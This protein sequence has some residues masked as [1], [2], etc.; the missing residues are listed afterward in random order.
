MSV[1]EQADAHSLSGVSCPLCARS[2][3]FVAR[4]MST[5]RLA[6]YWNELGYDLYTHFPQLKAGLAKC[7]CVDCDVRFFL[8]RAAG[9]PDLYNALGRSPVYY[10]AAKWEYEHVLRHLSARP[11]GGSL[12]EFGCGPGLF[13]QNAGAYFD[14]AVGLDFNEEAVNEAKSRGLDVRAAGLETLNETFDTIVAFQVIEHVPEPGETLRRLASLLKPGGELIVAV[15][16]ENGLLGSLEWNCL[17]M[18]PHHASCW[19]RQAFEAAASLT[20]LQLERYSVETLGLDL[21]LGSIHERFDRYL[22]GG[23]LLT[24]LMLWPIRR[25]AIA[26]ALVRYE[27]HRKDETG[28]THIAFFRKPASGG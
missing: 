13:L 23:G 9:G 26:Y 20:G 16:N 15:P 5:A 24:R 19:T 2:N 11:K 7:Q 10:P 21:Y 28:H 3:I 17:N 4:R 18:P 12:L 25:A 22:A 27:D 14:R 1:A 6:S 8:P